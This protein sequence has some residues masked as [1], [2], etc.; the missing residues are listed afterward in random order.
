MN[1]KERSLCELHELEKYFSDVRLHHLDKYRRWE[2]E[3]RLKLVQTE[4]KRRSG[5]QGILHQLTMFFGSDNWRLD[6]EWV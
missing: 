3:Q 4:I 2:A 5:I 6:S 1:L